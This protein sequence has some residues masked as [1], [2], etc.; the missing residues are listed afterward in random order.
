MHLT[1]KSILNPTG[2][3]RRVAAARFLGVDPIRIKLDGE[4][5][6]VAGDVHTPQG[7]M[8]VMTLAE[9]AQLADDMQDLIDGL[10]DA[11]LFV[12]PQGVA[13]VI[14]AV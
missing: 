6:S 8:W 12:D 2:D 3:D 10:C 4:G 13:W 14:S 1:L 5:R 11:E 7:D 9:K